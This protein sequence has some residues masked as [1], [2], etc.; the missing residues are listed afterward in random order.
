VPKVF[1]DTNILVYQ[2][3]KRDHTKRSV[4]RELVS[5]AAANGDAVI[6]TQVLQE[7]YVATTTKLHIDPILIK[8]ILHTFENM[9]VV[10]IGNDLIDDAI[11][12]SIQYKLSFWD[13]LIV[14]AAESAKCET[15]YTEDLNDGQTIRNVRITNPMKSKV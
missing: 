7:F 11:D 15:L 1:I 3:D 5:K 6:S 12:A 10:T 13:S 14:V 4:C 2:M 8:S 9:E